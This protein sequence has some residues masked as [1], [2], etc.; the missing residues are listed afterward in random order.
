ME[1]KSIRYRNITRP[2]QLFF[3]DTIAFEKGRVTITRRKWLGLGK[4][5][6]DIG[7]ARVASVEIHSGHLQRHGSR[8]GAGEGFS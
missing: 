8:A 5:E 6:D 4:S 1:V 3:P 2:T 7:I